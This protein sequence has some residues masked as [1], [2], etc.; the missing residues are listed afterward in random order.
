MDLLCHNDVAS[1]KNE[2]TRGLDQRK[3]EIKAEEN[4]VYASVDHSTTD[5]RFK[6]NKC[7]LSFLQWYLD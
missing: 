6:E 3:S 7:A 5:I 2:E 1:S 4:T